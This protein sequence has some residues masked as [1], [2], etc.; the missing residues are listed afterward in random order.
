MLSLRGGLALLGGLWK[1]LVPPGPL[2]QPPAPQ[3]SRDH[4][5]LSGCRAGEKQ[6]QVL[7]GDGYKPSTGT[8]TAWRAKVSAGS[9][10]PPP[11]TEV[12][13]LRRHWGGRLTEVGFSVL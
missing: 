7:G 12:N 9:S 13:Y 5:Q 6:K 8:C 2:S 3:D 4:Q 1:P 10:P 11:G